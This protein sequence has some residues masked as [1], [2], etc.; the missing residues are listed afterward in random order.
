[1]ITQEAAAADS[2]LQKWLSKSNHMTVS[3][4]GWSSRGKDEIYTVHV[5]TPTRRSFF[6]EGLVLIG[7]SVTSALLLQ[8][9]GEVC[10][11]DCDV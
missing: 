3:W 2:K 9:I 10:K 7:L 1:M 6:A 8:Q 5:T 4:D 11:S